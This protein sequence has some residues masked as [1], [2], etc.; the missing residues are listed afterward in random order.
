M[1]DALGASELPVREL[2]S[3]MAP[4]LNSQRGEARHSRVPKAWFTALRTLSPELKR[5]GAVM[6]STRTPAP[7]TALSEGARLVIRWSSMSSRRAVKL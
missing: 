2:S 7:I 4:T 1:A 3:I 6:R 5:M